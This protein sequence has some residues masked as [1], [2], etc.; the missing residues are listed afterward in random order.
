[1]NLRR[2][3][4]PG[5]FLAMLIVT[6][7]VPTPAPARP[8]FSALES[9]NCSYCHI[10]PTGGGQRNATGFFFGKDQLAM[11]ASIQSINNRFKE[12]GEFEPMIAE[13]IMLGTDTR[14]FYINI[15]KDD[16]YPDEVHGNSFQMMQAA[17][18]MDAQLLPILHAVAAYDMANTTFEAYGLI[19]NLPAG[20][21]ARF[22]RFILPF[23][24]RMD[25]HTL[26][27]RDGLGFG[28]LSQDSGVEVGVRPGPVTISAAVTNGAMGSNAP[29]Y[30]GSY[31]AATGQASV[32]FWK[33]A[34]GGNFFHNTQGGYDYDIYGAWFNFGI[35]N[36][37][38]LGEF[39]FYNKEQDVYPVA[40]TAVQ[41]PGGPFLNRMRKGTAGFFMVDYRVIQGLNLRARYS[42]EDPNLELDETWD[43]EI[44][45]GL[46]LYP[47]PY[48]GAEFQYRYKRE[49]E[50]EKRDNNLVVG[51]LHLYF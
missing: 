20:V 51:Q 29:D 19:D 49:P 23:G 6:L 45:G 2:A 10:N 44:M 12:F 5:L 22:G 17:A 18:Y 11:K 37:A 25:D 14:L 41:Y 33:V 16:D 40:S 15:G 31:F 47:M 26:F 42:H 32:R 9:K 27:T 50:V 35:W 3:F 8:E 4:V 43:D 21:Y 30:E 39:D 48:L 7:L 34:L 38:F 13:K 1:M 24:L 28:A 36:L 46:M